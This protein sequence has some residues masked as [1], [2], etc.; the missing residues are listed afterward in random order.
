MKNDR[1]IFVCDTDGF[2]DCDFETKDPELAGAHDHELD[3]PLD[4]SAGLFPKFLI[5]D[6]YDRLRSDNL[7]E[8]RNTEDIKRV[9]Q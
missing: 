5:I 7:V 1:W 3:R 8:D 2:E 9:L 4:H 6:G